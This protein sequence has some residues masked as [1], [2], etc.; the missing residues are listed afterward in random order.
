MKDK[1]ILFDIYHLPQYNF[2]R[3]AMQSLNEDQY[4][5]CALNRSKLGAIIKKEMP[6]SNVYLYGDYS[7]NKSVL[8]LVFLVIIPR[9]WKMVKLIKKNKYNFIISASYQ[10]NIIARFL[11]IPSI[12]FNDDPE[13]RNFDVVKL[14]ANEVIIPPLFNKPYRNV[15]IMNALKEWSYLSPRYFK[16]SLK[17][18]DM[19]LLEKRKFIFV[20]E[21]STKSLNYKGQKE[22]IILEIASRLPKNYTYVLSLENKETKALFPKDWIILEEPVTDIHSL[23]FYSRM[24]ISS[25]D[26]MAREGALLGVPAVYCGERNM[27]ANKLLIDKGYLHHLSKNELPDF[28]RNL[29]YSQNE[30][31]YRRQQLLQNWDDVTQLIINKINSYT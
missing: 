21:V 16:P 13:K 22:N 14:F 15:H 5:I 7:K 18:L 1:Y 23:L 19:Y 9:M 20:R 30:Q 2:F 11:G 26:S 3:N 27:R 12:A 25:G 28:I 29:E 17:S 10:S 24:V 6:S 8:S 31:E 4:D